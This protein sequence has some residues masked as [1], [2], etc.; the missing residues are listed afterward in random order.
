MKTHFRWS[1]M[2]GLALA[3]ALSLAGCRQQTPAY[4][5]RFPAFGTQFD[6]TIVGVDA[7]RAERAGAQIQRDFE[8]MQSAWQATDAGPLVRVNELLGKGR[9]CAA[10]PSILPL[11]RVGQ[12]LA[13]A[14]DNLFNPAA[15]KLTD[16][17]GFNKD[18]GRIHDPPSA[19]QIGRLV[20]ANPR[21]ADLQV[22]GIRV[23]SDN[24][25]LKLDFS[26]LGKG[27]GMDLAIAHL[28]DLGIGNAMIGADG[29]VRAIGDRDGQGWR[30]PIRR[31]TGPGVFA[32][33][34]IRGDESVFTRA[35][36]QKSFTH[37]GTVYHHILDPRT[38][39]PARD[40]LAVTVVHTDAATADAAATALFVAG[41]ADGFRIAE[42]MGI[43][44]VFLVDSTGTVHMNPPMANRVQMLDQTAEIKL[45]PLPTD[46]VPGH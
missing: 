7:T 9:P 13:N 40:T 36:Y 17:W 15:G 21:M 37:E 18:S 45:T 16:L 14:S 46:P 43:R 29:D 26:S 24:P 2:L 31:P 1:Q 20:K 41:A 34:E 6:L 8:L 5:T 23:R 22:E 35:G 30:V 33:V 39:Y 19:K 44:Y 12:D 11:I 25:A 3:L 4:T 27:Y 10:P 42:R 38:G 28:R 32:V